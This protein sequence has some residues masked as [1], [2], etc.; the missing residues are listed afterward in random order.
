MALLGLVL[1]GL[2]LLVMVWLGGRIVRRLAQH[3]P[4]PRRVGPSD[5]EPQPF[6]ADND[7]PDDRAPPN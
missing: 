6:A 3:R 7:V 4:P 1:L 2:T 5:W